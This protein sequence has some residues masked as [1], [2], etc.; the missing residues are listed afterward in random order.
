[1]VWNEIDYKRN[2]DQVIDDFIAKYIPHE[3]KLCTVSRNQINEL[4]IELYMLK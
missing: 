4:R 2:V 1:M 3:K